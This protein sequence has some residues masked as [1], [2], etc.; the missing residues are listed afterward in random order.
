MSEK[1]C[2]FAARYVDDRTSYMTSVDEII[3]IAIRE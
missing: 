3:V 2:N 1:C